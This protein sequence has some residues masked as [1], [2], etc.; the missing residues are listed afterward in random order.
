[1]T[2]YPM[3]MNSVAPLRKTGTA[4]ELVADGVNVAADDV[5]RLGVEAQVWRQWPARCRMENQVS[6]ARDRPYHRR[7][8]G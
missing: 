6:G 7:R 8:D 2:V 3:W 5:S 1:M 4:G